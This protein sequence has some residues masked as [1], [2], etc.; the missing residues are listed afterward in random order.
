MI[1]FG[2]S[3]DVVGNRRWDDYH[4]CS[5]LIE[6]RCIDVERPVVSR[7]SRERLTEDRFCS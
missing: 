4:E 7:V 1:L 5:D 6:M 2:L 3:Q